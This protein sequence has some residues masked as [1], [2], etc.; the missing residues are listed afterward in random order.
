MQETI[1]RGMADGI[2]GSTTPSG[3]WEENEAQEQL[4]HL[5]FCKQKAEL[6]IST[7]EKSTK[8]KEIL[9]IQQKFLA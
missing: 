3:N 8:C 2:T 4:S 5:L 6:A 1:P 7:T 9:S